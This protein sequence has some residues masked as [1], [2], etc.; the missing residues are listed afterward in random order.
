MTGTLIVSLDCE[1][2]WGMADHDEMLGQHP[3]GDTNL[4][5]A[6]EF[7]FETLERLNIRATF[8][9]V[10]LF[11]AG[12][13]EAEDYIH[14]TSTDPVSQGWLTKPRKA[15]KNGQTDGWFFED[16][17]NL[18]L[19]SGKHELASH[20][21]SHLP[22]TSSA[23][24]SVNAHRELNAMR[25]L[26]SRKGWNIRTMVFPRNQIT[27]TD[28]LGE[29]GIQ[30]YRASQ[31]NHSLAGRAL[32][33]VSEFNIFSQSDEPPL[34]DNTVSAGR[35][36]NWRSGPRRLVPARV[37]VQRWKSIL[38]HATKNDG[39]AHLWF[40]PHNL[41]TGTA[42]RELVTNVLELAGASVRS[43]D[44]HSATFSEVR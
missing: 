27:H 13:N 22:F 28:L 17:P 8:A 44:L 12:K 43:G 25:D 20:G 16:L 29:Y 30:K 2:R 9:V 38:R 18:V 5:L 15:I 23:F 31:E 1:G 41:I 24:T 26:A 37:T 19:E 11:V 40:H 35:F 42:Q 39:C 34:N 3:I 33:L 21:Y 36:L 14:Q 6:Y 7:L 10:G 4:R 32:S